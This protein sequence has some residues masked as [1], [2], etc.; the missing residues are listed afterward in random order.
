MSV[1]KELLYA[2][3]CLSFAIVIGAAVYEHIAVVPR[4][5]A[6]PP[7]SLTMF[8]GKYGLD[9]A[10]FWKLIHPVTL[11]LLITTLVIFWKT[12]SRMHLVVPLSV[13]VAILV[14]TATYFVPQLLSI[15]QTPV[16]ET[17]DALLT[18]RAKTWETLSLARLCVLAVLA[19]GAGHCTH[20]VILAQTFHAI[21]F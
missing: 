21:C 16:S 4:W 18:S 3:T 12:G 11:L 7:A 15:V 1:I 8:Q 20:P 17:A 10:P 9:A 5:S 6:A 2:L 19:L 14:A 13:Y